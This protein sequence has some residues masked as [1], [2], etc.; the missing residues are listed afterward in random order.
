MSVEGIWIPLERF[1]ADYWSVLLWKD[2]FVNL[3]KIAIFYQVLQGQEFLWHL[4]NLNLWQ[5][6]AFR[7]NSIT[8]LDSKAV[9]FCLPSES[10]LT[11]LDYR[12]IPAQQVTTYSA[13]C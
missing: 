1:G 7:A 6:I 5:P 4:P 9:T 8:N 2:F 11:K 12:S 3:S 13:T 10:I